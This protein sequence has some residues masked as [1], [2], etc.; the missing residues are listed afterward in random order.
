MME[1]GSSSFSNV[2][3]LR[4]IGLPKLRRVMIGSNSFT[5]HKNGF[6]SDP[7]RHFY[8]K[9]CPKIKE[10]KV[11]GFSFS[12]YGVCEIEDVNALEMIEMSGATFQ[13]T[14]LELRSVVT[15]NG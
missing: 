9:N 3:E 10:L 5:Q 1:I 14:S 7:N 15:E 6:G 4:L 12:D 8:L 2:N 13:F 11:D